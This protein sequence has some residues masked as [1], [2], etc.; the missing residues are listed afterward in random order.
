[1]QIFLPQPLSFNQ[2]FC[3]EVLDLLEGVFSRQLDLHDYGS[4]DVVGQAFDNHRW[5]NS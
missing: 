3:P 4:I 1:M 5:E 2:Q